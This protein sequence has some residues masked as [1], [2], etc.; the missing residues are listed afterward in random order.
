MGSRLVL[1]EFDDES[2][3]EAFVEN[4]HLPDQLGFEVQGMWFMTKLTCQCGGKRNNKD[5]G[6]GRRTGIPLCRRC[7]KPSRHWR[8]GL[9]TRLRTALGY[10]LLEESN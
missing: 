5:W 7:R 2:S 9:M 6:R 1:L 8:E 10:N 3:A 4:R